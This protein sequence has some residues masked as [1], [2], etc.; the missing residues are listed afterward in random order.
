MGKIAAMSIPRFTYLTPGPSALYFTLESHLKTALKEQIPSISHRSPGFQKIFQETAQNLRELFTLPENYHVLFTGSANE[1]WERLLE[2]CVEKESFH[3]VNG[4]FSRK[5]FS[6]AQ[7]LGKNALH[8]AAAPGSCVDIEQLMVPESAEMIAFT[9]NETST[10]VAQPLEDIYRIRKAFPEAI[11]S[12]DIV[13]SA[14][15][16]DL[17]FSQVD[18]AYFSVQKCFGLPAG[19]GVWLVNDRCLEKAKK[20]QKNGHSIGTYHTLPKLVESAAKFQTPETP[21]ML[22]IYLLGKIAGDMLSKGLDQ[23]RRETDYK[24]A[25]LYHMLESHAHFQ[26]FV[27]KPQQRSKTVIV[28]ETPIESGEIIAQLQAKGLMVGGGYG[29]FKRHHFRVANFPTHSKETIEMLVDYLAE[30]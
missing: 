26:P 25:L 18:S 9:H 20:L 29:E 1:I 15:Y 8:S 10:G 27:S 6:F 5:F 23:I 14:P 12:V 11:I 4:A 19:L 17:D 7:A 3:L 22:G 24:A 2:N 13:S 30:L 28:A 16:V 21:N